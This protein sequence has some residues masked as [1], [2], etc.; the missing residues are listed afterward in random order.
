MGKPVESFDEI[1]VDILL[2]YK[3]TKNL[4]I[5]TPH[6]KERKATITKGTF[7]FRENYCVV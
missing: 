4:G 5:K 2:Y 7:C 6:H 1:L 3:I